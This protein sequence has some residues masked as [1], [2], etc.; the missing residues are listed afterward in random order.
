MQTEEFFLFD[1]VNTIIGT[2][3]FDPNTDDGP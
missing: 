1:T 2:R 3:V